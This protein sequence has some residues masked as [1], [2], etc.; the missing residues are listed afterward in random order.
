MTKQSINVGTSAN[1]RKGDSLRAAFTKVNNNFDEL[2][3]ALG[4]ND[5]TLNLGAFTFTGST[6]STDDSTNIVIDKPITVNGEITV[7][8]DILPKTNLG[9]SLGS[10]TQQFKSLYVSTNTIY[11]NNVPLTLD[12]SNNILVN[13]API[14]NSIDVADL[15]DNTGLLTEIDGGNAS[16]DS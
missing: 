15:T 9:V 2:Y 10:P 3:T 8:G 14:S 13:N 11:I 5:V 16:S 1:D 7:D 4:L 12:S 6:M